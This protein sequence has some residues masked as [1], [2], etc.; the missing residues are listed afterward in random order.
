MKVLFTEEDKKDLFAWYA[1]C[2]FGNDGEVGDVV[3]WYEGAKFSFKDIEIEVE[4]GKKEK[5]KKDS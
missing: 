1:E 4:I 5:D 3:F 2:V